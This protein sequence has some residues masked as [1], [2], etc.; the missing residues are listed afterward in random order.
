[1][2]HTHPIS[3]R[4]CLAATTFAVFC[5]CA[6]ISTNDPTSDSDCDQPRA[7][8]G[9]IVMFD[10]RD[11]EAWVYFDVET[12]SIVERQ[13]PENSGE[14]DLGLLRFNVSVNGGTS[15]AGG[16]EVAVLRDVAFADVNIA[17]TTGYVTDNA[18]NGPADMETMPGF[19]F[20]LW[21]DYDISRHVL[22]PTGAVYVVRTVEG[23]YFKVEVLDY[24]DGAGSPGYLTLLW[25]PVDP[26]S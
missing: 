22:E 13:T 4:L 12:D 9:T 11:D 17:P 10:A 1:V 6:H 16:V 26:P 20:D 19:A 23:S 3:A 7:D 14:W 21:Y 2:P 8:E 24:Y 5:A 18:A 25:D 15:G